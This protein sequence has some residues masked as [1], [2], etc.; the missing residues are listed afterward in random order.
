MKRLIRRILKE[1]DFDW[2]GEVNVNPWLEYDIIMFDMTPNRNKVNEYIEMALATRK[3]SNDES[4][5]VG[6]EDD[7]DSII[8]YQERRGVCYLGI[9]R[10]NK[11]SYCNILDYFNFNGPVDELIIRYSD[12]INLK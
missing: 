4:W 8:G 6:R 10:T 3:P 7:I 1:S 9:D 12:L 5:E 2:V 11:L